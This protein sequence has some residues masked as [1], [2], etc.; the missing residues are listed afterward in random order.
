[1]RGVASSRGRIG[2]GAAW[3]RLESGIGCFPQSREGMAGT[4]G[5]AD[6]VAGG[7]VGGEEE[8]ARLAAA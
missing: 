5:L 6:G 4:S 2:Y 1:M 7:G 3:I 8:L